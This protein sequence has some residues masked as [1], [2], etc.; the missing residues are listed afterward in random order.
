MEGGEEKVKGR[1]AM[2]Q[3]H[4]PVLKDFDN[5]GGAM[6]GMEQDADRPKRPE[7]GG[8]TLAARPARRGSRP[9]VGELSNTSATPGAVSWR[10]NYIRGFLNSRNFSGNDVPVKSE[11]LGAYTLLTPQ[12]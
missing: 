3:D 11:V 10:T 8:P 1:P 5:G 4:D 12:T 7:G 2:S 6:K 9:E